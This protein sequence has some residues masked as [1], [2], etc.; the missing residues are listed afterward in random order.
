MSL[1]LTNIPGI[2]RHHGWNNGARLLEIWFSLPAAVAPAYGAPDTN[3][4]RMDRFVLTFARAKQ[5]YDQL[6]AERIWVNLAAQREIARMLTRSLLLTNRPQS[7]GNFALPVPQIDTDYV[8]YRTVGFT[9]LDD[10]TASLGNFPFRVAV[11]GTVTPISGGRGHTV[12]VSEVAVYVRDSFDF[13]GEQFLGY[14]DDSD[15][16]VGMFNPL[17][18]TG[19]N[20]S[21]FRA[22][23]A[24]TGRGGDF[25]VYSDLKIL[26]WDP[27]DRFTI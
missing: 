19:V 8:N 13:N 16:S 9:D 14:W 17:S 24:T 7:F 18:G 10:L 4:I 11:K 2:M 3:T 26:R 25:L 23:R 21:D 6:V 1:S 20:N 12:A 5:V 27:P 15:S 22:W